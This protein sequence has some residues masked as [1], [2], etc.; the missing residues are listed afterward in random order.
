MPASSRA[1]MDEHGLLY[2]NAKDLGGAR[3]L[4]SELLRLVAACLDGWVVV[5]RHF[6]TFRV[7]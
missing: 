5:L 1:Y 2:C 3:R 7:E 6:A 4:I